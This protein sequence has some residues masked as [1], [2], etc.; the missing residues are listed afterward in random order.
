MLSGEHDRLPDPHPAQVRFPRVG[1]AVLAVA[2]LAGFRHS[3]PG[4]HVHDRASGGLRCL[5]HSNPGQADGRRVAAVWRKVVLLQSR[6]RPGHGPGAPGRC[7]GGYVGREPVPVAQAAPGRFAQRLPDSAFERQTRHA[8]DGQRRDHPGRRHRLP[9]W[10][11]RSRL[12]ANGRHGQYVA[13]VQRRACGRLDASGRQ[14][15]DVHRASSS[16]LRQALDRHAADAAPTAEN[17]VAHRA[18]T[19]DVH[20]NRYAAAQGRCRR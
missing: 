1:G 10:R 18:G 2:G 5:A 15:S 6:C 19:L 13:L 17:D 3:V 7:A 9:D 16:G 12:P 4:R 14:R 20:A 8:L 11:S